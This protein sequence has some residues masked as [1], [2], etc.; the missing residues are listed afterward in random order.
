VPI[1][2]VADDMAVTRER[3]FDEHGV[4]ASSVERA[5]R[6]IRDPDIREMAPAFEEHLT[7]VGELTAPG[8]VTV[9]PRSN[10]SGWGGR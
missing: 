7:D 9:S 1:A 4:V 6:L 8:R 3:V 5:P 2:G 10:G